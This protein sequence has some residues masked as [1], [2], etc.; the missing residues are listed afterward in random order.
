MTVSLRGNLEDFG[1]PEIFQLIGQQRKTG[2]LEFSRPGESIRISFCQG[3]VL[4][5]EPVAAEPESAYAEWLVR[6]GVLTQEVAHRVLRE[7]REN[8]QSVQGICSA[9]GLAA[10]AEL[11]EVRALLTRESVFSVLAWSRGQFHFQAQE[12]AVGG[13]TGESLAAEQILMEGL[14]VLDESQ[15]F[16]ERVPSLDVVFRSVGTLASLRQ[17]LPADTAAERIFLRID[18][19]TSAQRAIDLTRL[20]SFEGTRAL[21]E[22]CRCGLIEATALRRPRSAPWAEVRSSGPGVFR[23]A[24]ATWLP[25]AL[26]LA[27]LGFAE[28]R[29]RSE[30]GPRAGGVHWS[31]QERL[32]S[33]FEARR[34]RH[35]A[36][37]CRLAQGRYP[38]RLEELL[39][40]GCFA[41]GS[42][43]G[44][45]LTPYYYA[46]RDGEMLLLAPA[47]SPR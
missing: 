20:G 6:C 35:A 44:A 14:R 8:A 40:G 10:A 32:R 23:Q 24:C 46:L 38:E 42:L 26:L 15:R 7:C 1:I 13:E 18:G 31:V 29:M 30:R 45:D 28:G 19:R 43:A 47:H 33:G 16:A 27:A 21:A 5:A 12:I 9:G 4:R 39:A 17:Q 37:A 41:A 25:I 3:S 22:L 34:V 2:V 11:A 36:E